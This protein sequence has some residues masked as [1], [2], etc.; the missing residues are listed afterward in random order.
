[1][2]RRS[3]FALPAW[4]A[5]VVLG[6]VIIA[7]LTPQF[8]RNQSLLNL[9][10]LVFLSITLSQSWNM[11]AGF[12]GQISLGHA[13][14]FGIGALITRS[15]WISGTPFAAAM[16]VGGVVPALFALLIGV[17][18]FR[19]RGAYFSIGTLAMAE[20][21]HVTVANGLPFVTTMSLEAIA[22]YELSER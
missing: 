17:P 10:F 12:A 7:M 5:L 19:L 18:T 15:L 6:V 21:L 3:R 1:M 8:T 13:A 11:L 4:R 22:H 9:C 2:R 14:F 16:F 20:A